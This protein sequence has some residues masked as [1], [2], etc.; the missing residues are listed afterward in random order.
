MYSRP[1]VRGRA[2]GYSVNVHPVHM[3][4][5]AAAEVP[6]GLKVTGNSQFPSG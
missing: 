3:S 6:I 2:G 1:R 4:I 5:S